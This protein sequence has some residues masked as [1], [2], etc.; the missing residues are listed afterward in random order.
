[1]PFRTAG[2]QPAIMI[3]SRLEAGGPEVDQF[4]G[5]TRN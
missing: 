4:S 1:M 5:D 2:F 3:M